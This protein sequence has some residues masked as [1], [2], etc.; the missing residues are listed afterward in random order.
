MEKTKTDGIKNLNT[1]LI[2]PAGLQR[3]KTKGT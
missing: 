1:A 2:S 3:D